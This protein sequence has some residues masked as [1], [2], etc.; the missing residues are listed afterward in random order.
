MMEKSDYI[1]G[2]RAVIEAIE[3]G[4]EIDKIMV[5]KDLQGDLA[6]ELFAAARQ[7]GAPIQRVPVERINRITRKNHQGV[8]AFLSAVEYYTLD[9]LVPQLYEAGEVPFV[10][11]LDGVTDVRNFG[12]IARTCECVGAHAIVIPARGSVSVNADAVK[13]SAGALHTL[14]V[15]RERSIQEAVKYLH[16]SGFTIVAASEKSDKNYTQ[17]DY[18]APVAI[19]MG[20]EDTG[21][22]PAVLRYCDEMV[23]IP[24]RGN[25]GSLNVSVAAGVMMYEVVRQRG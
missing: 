25:I 3:A 16:D 14:P 19:V 15:C 17:V 8:V 1:F 20:A 24:M 23:A 13:T 10:V 7:V 18:T 21:V 5:K 22:S 12:A 4:K 11:L 9:A 2:I 6:Q